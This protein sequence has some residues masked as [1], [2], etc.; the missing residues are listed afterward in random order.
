MSRPRVL[1]TR[2]VEHARGLCDAI[3]ARGGQPVELPLLEYA[4]GPDELGAV[5]READTYVALTSP[6][7][8]DAAKGVAAKVAVV[9]ESTRAVAV[10]AGLDVVLTAD[11]SG[12]AALADALIAAG[13]KEVVWACGDRALPALESKLDAAGVT[14]I[15]KVVYVTLMRTFEPAH[16]ADAVAHL[17]AVTFTSPSTVTALAGCGIADEDLSRLRRTVRAAAIGMTTAAALKH[18]GFLQV[19]TA[20]EP[21]NEALAAA[22]L[23]R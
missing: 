4:S 14:V 5:S 2:A 21:T 15:R 6:A 23:G 13:A 10:A 8:V 11:G 7:A 20:M 1:V 12:A 3:V 17:A 19:R 16:V 18:A 9:G 22:A